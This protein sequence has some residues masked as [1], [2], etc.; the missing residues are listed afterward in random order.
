MSNIKHFFKYSFSSLIGGLGQFIVLPIF[1]KFISATDYGILALAQVFSGIIFGIIN[2]GLPIS[3]ERNFFEEKLNEKSAELIYSILTYI[4]VSFI[5]FSII[6]FFSRNIVSF[7]LFGSKNYGLLL[8]FSYFAI[9]ISSIKNYYLIYFKNNLNSTSFLKYSIDDTVLTL[10]LSVFFVYYLRVGVI[11]LIYSQLISGSAVLIFLTY[12]FLKI[13]SYKFDYKMLLKSMKISLPLTPKIFVGI[14]GKSIDK[15][16]LNIF[17]STNGVGLISIANR[18]SN[19]SFTFLTSIENIYS[20]KT[21]K[22]MFEN[23]DEKKGGILIG[24]LLTPYIYISVF[25]CMVIAFVSYEVLWMLTP[26]EFHPAAN[27]VVILGMYTSILFFG[28][29]PQL[30]YKKKAYVITIIS[31]MTVG[32]GFVFTYI[33]AYKFLIIGAALGTFISGIITGCLYFFYSQKAYK[34][35]WETEKIISFYFTFFLGGTILIAGDLV[36][37]SYH[38]LAAIKVLVFSVYILLGFNYK[39]VSTNLLKKII[40]GKF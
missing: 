27:L 24:I 19:L 13:E 22:L 1:T 4:W 39:I 29:I 25:I 8:L 15:I 10:L 5:F 2:F 31:I 6:F 18:F 12:N 11:G 21:Y 9:G 17:N 30:M 33:L 7:H 35:Y 23:K 34:I 3:Y 14:L 26:N 28:K 40:Y 32:I 38:Y 37:I 36:G 16:I 20:P